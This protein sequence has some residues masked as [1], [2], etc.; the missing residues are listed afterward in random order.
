MLTFFNSGIRVLKVK[1]KYT[2]SEDEISLRR[3]KAER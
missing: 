1:I 3:N 2:R